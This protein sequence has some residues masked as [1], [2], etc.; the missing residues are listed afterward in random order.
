MSLADSTSELDERPLAPESLKTR[1]AR[2]KLLKQWEE[3]KQQFTPKALADAVSKIHKWIADN[4]KHR[5]PIKEKIELFNQNKD[6]AA[7]S[8]K[9][10]QF[11]E[12]L[13][14]DMQYLGRVFEHPENPRS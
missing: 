12:R 7:L 1:K 4:A 11:A 6:A 13:K 2:E 8:R 5:V 9:V 14:T 3:E 10:Q